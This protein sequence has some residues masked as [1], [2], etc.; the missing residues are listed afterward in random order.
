MLELFTPIDNCIKGFSACFLWMKES[1]QQTVG[2][3]I[4][5]LA[6]QESSRSIRSRIF[7][8]KSNKKQHNVI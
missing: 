7:T 2:I 6:R 5:D 3:D 4:S 8:R 1:T